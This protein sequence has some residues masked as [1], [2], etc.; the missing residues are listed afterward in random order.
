MFEDIRYEGGNGKP[1]KISWQR[2]IRSGFVAVCGKGESGTYSI[3]NM[4]TG[5]G[6][7]ENLKGLKK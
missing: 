3:F 7:P 6:V 4:K 2:P 1:P 5:N